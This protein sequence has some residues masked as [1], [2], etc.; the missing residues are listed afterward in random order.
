MSSPPLCYGTNVE[1]YL[2]EGDRVDIYWV[3]VAAPSTLDVV[4]YNPPNTDYDLIIYAWTAPNDPVGRSRSEGPGAERVVV[5]VDPGRYY[6]AVWPL[7]G[8]SDL[9]YLLRWT[10]R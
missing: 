10:A 1:G 4:L 6:V 2:R 9:A 8:S 3:E 5:D 7:A